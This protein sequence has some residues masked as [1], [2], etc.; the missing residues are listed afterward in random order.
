MLVELEVPDL[1]DIASERKIYLVAELQ[2]NSP[3]GLAGSCY[4]AKLHSG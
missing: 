1:A 3:R 2:G 4:V